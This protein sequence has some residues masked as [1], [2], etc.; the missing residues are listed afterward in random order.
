[1]KPF[2]QKFNSYS[3]CIAF[4]LLLGACDQIPSNKD[5]SQPVKQSNKSVN[6]TL[7]GAEGFTKVSNAPVWLVNNP[8]GTIPN[9]AFIEGNDGLIVIDT[10]LKIADA[11]IALGYIRTV[12]DKPIRA[13]IYT[14][15]HV[16]HTSGTKVFVDDAQQMGMTDIPI[17]ASEYLLDEYQDENAVTG[18][19]MA[20]RA[21]YM[22]GTLLYDDPQHDSYSVGLSGRV[23]TG[24]SGFIQPTYLIK[25]TVLINIAGVE[26]QI[27]PTGGEAA[28]HIGVYMP[29]GGIL[30]SGDEI[31]GPT[32][33]NLHSLRGT[34]PRDANKWI[35]AL[36][37]MR[38][39]KPKVLVPSHGW[40]TEG[41][42]NVEAILVTY[43]DAIQWT[44]DQAVRLINQGYTQDE[45][46]EAM[47][48]LPE[49][50]QSDPW[51]KEYYGTVK[52]SVRNYYTGYI[53]WFDGDPATLDPLP[54]LERAKRYVALMG[55]RGS[56]IAEAQHAKQNQD[57]R[58][59]A[60]LTTYLIRVNHDDQEA[61]T[62]KA[63]AFRQLAI[64][65]INTNWQGFYLTGALELEG[66]VDSVALQNDLRLLFAPEHI[67]TDRL[68]SLFRYSLN[69]EKS[70]GKSASVVFTFPD[71]G[72]SFTLHMRN[73]ILEIQLG[74]DPQ[75]TAELSMD[76][77]ILNGVLKGELG[78]IKEMLVGGIDLKGSKLDALK[79]LGALD[80][81]TVPIPLVVR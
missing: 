8:G 10:G 45:L 33:P 41:T 35:A 7:K 16:D 24:S 61:R 75:A 43:R 39:F 32:F 27:F 40:I 29:V 48:A 78:F 58:W 53:S 6:E 18:R 60:E 54:R 38:A 67:S 22:Y 1:M 62:L 76:R 11:V 70:A 51:T 25:E 63:W 26:L 68:L 73:Q 36:D 30:F 49:A 79:L 57:A 5:A 66:H 3:V 9:I 4:L 13:I 21:M 77:I 12:S 20:L 31:Q 34:K 71:T 44:H 80:T 15:H 19:I 59:V 14:H 55:G 52:H 23:I 50:L 69:P 46:A 28:S 81:E 42:E 65:T 64:E 72:E 47:P 37:R 2:K 17:I 56:V 74:K